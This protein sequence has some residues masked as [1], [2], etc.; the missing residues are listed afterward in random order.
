MHF[1]SLGSYI[2]FGAGYGGY[3]RICR[4][5]VSILAD[6]RHEYRLGGSFLIFHVFR[7][8]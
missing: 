8:N 3:L 5:F 7:V 2:V 1:C 6:I 4:A